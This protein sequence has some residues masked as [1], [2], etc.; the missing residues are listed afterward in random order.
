[1]TEW[2]DRDWVTSAELAAIAGISQRTLTREV[3][4]GNLK[5]ARASAYVYR[6]DDAER[7]L[8]SF[9]KYDAL[10]KD[11]TPVPVP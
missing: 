7:W 5:A 2:P 6:T 10:H 3:K 4:R 1:M 11:S 8:A 9:R